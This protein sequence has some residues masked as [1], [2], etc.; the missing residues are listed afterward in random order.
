MA[1]IL[2]TRKVQAIKTN[3]NLTFFSPHWWREEER[4]RR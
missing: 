1:I 3:K 4:K 2:N